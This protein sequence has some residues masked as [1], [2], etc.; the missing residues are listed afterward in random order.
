MK[1]LFVVFYYLSGNQEVLPSP[2][3]FIQPM[4]TYRAPTLCQSLFQAPGY[5]SDQDKHLCHQ[6]AYSPVV[7]FNLPCSLHTVFH[8]PSGLSVFFF[9][10]HHPIISA[11]TAVLLLG[12][13]GCA[14]LT[15]GSLRSTQCPCQ[16]SIEGLNDIIKTPCSPQPALFKL[17]PV[18]FFLTGHSPVA[19]LQQPTS[20]FFLF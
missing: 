20:H 10:A 19:Q 3:R 17:G 12:A 13:E 6:G 14:L 9:C 4:H 1:S 18:S 11:P 16:V 7:S 5:S 2:L 15:S 8:V